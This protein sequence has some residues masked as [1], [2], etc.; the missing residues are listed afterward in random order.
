MDSF[1]VNDEKFKGRVAMSEN[2]SEFTKILDETDVK[3]W[4]KTDAVTDRFSRRGFRVTWIDWNSDFR[5]TDLQIEDVIVG[6]DDVSLEPF[7]EPGNHG[8]AIGQYGE[9]TYWQKLGL[10]HN[11]TITL[12]VYRPG[13]ASQIEISAKLLAHRFYSDKEEKRSLAP[14]GPQSMSRDNFSGAWSS[15]YEDLVSRMSYI[16]DGG[17]DNKSINTTREL[18]DHLEKKKRINYLTENYPGEFAKVTLSDWQKVHDV[19]FGK[20]IDEVD[21]EYRELG[22][23]RVETVKQ[24]AQR[25][26]DE[27]NTKLQDKIISSFPVIDVNERESVQGKIVILPWISPRNIINDLG[28]T[29]AAIGN[30]VEG[31]YFAQ[32]SDSPSARKMYDLMYEYHSQVSPNLKERFQYVGK[33]TGDPALITYDNKAVTGLM[34]E[35][36]AARAGDGEFFVDLQDLQET[37]TE[38]SES[39]E[40]EDKKI[41]FAG[42][43]AISQFAPI[44][45]EDD[46]TPQKV[47]EVMIDTVK[48]AHEQKWKSLFA[49][50]RAYRYWEDRIA[51]DPSYIPASLFPTSW[52][53]SRKLISDRVY[54]VR[55]DK[56]GPVRRLI[57]KDEE[58]GYPNVDEVDVFVDHYEKI[59]EKYRTFLDVNV[60]RKWTLQRLNEG[61]W[62]ITTVQVI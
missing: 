46:A 61:P 53:N 19:L 25:A 31:Y 1:G 7:L 55:V 12:K 4:I 49:T 3:T 15:W 14:G 35:I 39:N 33:I 8:S 32:L 9:T 54:D 23:K 45:L 47:I 10:T 44:S 30:R 40:V 60:R 22:A 20:E 11:H 16:L 57:E 59:D 5:N 50:W 62:R 18:Q 27:M 51:F 43:E 56:T 58:A 13:E 17:L 24:E 28:Q 41:R 26:W 34:V 21:L 38:E 42:Q 48:L 29:F 2:P 37:I 6:Y 36:I 52:K